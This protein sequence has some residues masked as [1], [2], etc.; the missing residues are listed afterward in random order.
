MSLVLRTG[1]TQAPSHTMHAILPEV[2]YDEAN[3]SAIEESGRD[4]REPHDGFGE[5]PRC[6]PLL[7]QLSLGTRLIE[8]RGAET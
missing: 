4:R 5:A 7:V 1:L 8:S 6:P 3:R 2:G